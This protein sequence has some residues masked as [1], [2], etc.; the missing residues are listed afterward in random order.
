MV[1]H[2]FLHLL[3]TGMLALALEL[4]LT[5]AALAATAALVL[6]ERVTSSFLKA[7]VTFSRVMSLPAMRRMAETSVE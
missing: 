7:S 1:C 5:R 2:F 3:Q 6:D 4:A